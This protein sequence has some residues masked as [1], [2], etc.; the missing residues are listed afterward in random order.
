MYQWRD[1]IYGKKAI[2]VFILVPFCLTFIKYVGEIDFF[3]DFIDTVGLTSLKVKL[4]SWANHSGDSG[5]KHL[6]F[7]IIVLDIFYLFVPIL[8][9]KIFLKKEKLSEFGLSVKLEKGWWKIYLLFMCFMFPLVYYF[10]GTT[11]F[12]SRYPFYNIADSTPLWPKFW[13]WELLYFSQFFCLE[14]FFRGFMVHGLK[15]KLGIYSVFVMTIPYCMIHFGKPMPE[16]ISAIF[17]GLILGYLSYKNRSILLGFMLHITVAISMDLLALW[18]EG[19][20]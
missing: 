2:L 7:W 13:I 9:I 17:A 5:L 4:D 1:L 19:R 14:F 11:S 20:W 8:F 15:E 6:A 18:R 12:Q 16:T 3:I 10:S